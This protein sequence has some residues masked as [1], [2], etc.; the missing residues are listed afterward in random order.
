MMNLSPAMASYLKEHDAYKSFL[1]GRHPASGNN[2]G[3]T[4][5]NTDRANAGTDNDEAHI[6]SRCD[7]FSDSNIVPN[8]LRARKAENLRW[9]TR[10]VTTMKGCQWKNME[11]NSMKVEYGRGWMYRTYMV[12]KSIGLWKEK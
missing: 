5:L 4:G 2:I 9:R 11:G 10:S 1:V 6:M 7:S 12:W 8:S 3:E